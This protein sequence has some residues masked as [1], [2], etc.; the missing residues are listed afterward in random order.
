MTGMITLETGILADLCLRMIVREAPVHCLTIDKKQYCEIMVYSLTVGM[1][2]ERMLVHWHWYGQLACGVLAA[3]LL[4]ASIQDVQSREVYDFLHLMALPAGLV[5]VW[6]EVSWDK[7]ISLAVFAVVQ[8]G[9]F[10]RMYGAGDGLAFLVCAVFE[11]RFGAG[12]LTY[13]LHMSAAYVLLGVVQGI[14]GNLNRQGNLRE[15]VAFIPYIAVTT[16]IFL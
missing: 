7:L 1:W 8:F 5:F 14:R 3:Y 12:M 16:W 13:L 2:I 15:P 10:M 9:I 11:S 4:V 6:T